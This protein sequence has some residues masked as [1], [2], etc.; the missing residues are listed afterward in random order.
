MYAVSSAVNRGDKRDAAI[1]VWDLQ[2]GCLVR[3]FRGGVVAPRSLAISRG[4]VIAAQAG[5]P[6]IHV[7][8]PHSEHLD[9]R[10]GLGETCASLAC[11]P[12]DFLCVSG[13]ASG[14]IDVWEMATGE[15]LSSTKSAHYRRITT[16]RFTNDGAHVVTASDDA[17][18]KVWRVRDLVQQTT[19]E[20]IT[21]MHTWA[22]HTLPV[23]DV[24]VGFGSL[25]ARIVSASKDC[26]CKI[27]ELMTGENIASLAFPGDVLSVTMDATEQV[28]YA[29]TG[30]GV[31]YGA[32]LHGQSADD[33]RA[34]S[35]TP[36]N[37]NT[38]V[39]HTMPV[40][41]LD[42]TLDAC[43]L[44]SGSDD[45]T[46]RVWDTQSCQCVKI[47]T[48]KERVTSLVLVP[49]PWIDGAHPTLASV[50][51]PF[52]RTLS[53]ARDAD[54]VD[55]TKGVPMRLAGRTATSAHPPL[56]DTDG[57]DG[58]G[59]CAATDAL[60]HHMMQHHRIEAPTDVPQKSHH[61][62]VDELA[63]DGDDVASLKAAIRIWKAAATSLYEHCQRTAGL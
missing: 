47:Y 52:A 44:V 35:I 11:S 9:F 34:S 7:W 18:I 61:E 15:L 13:S 58:G 32:A 20:D 12:D 22:D 59:L 54:A 50:V 30:S 2:S 17:T 4:A 57:S 8:Q 24:F 37:L 51:T 5:K 31:V 41:S 3:A 27:W 40:T 43:T 21:P 55:A 25:S 46:V 39:G 45:G 1:H 14:R 38:Y 53:L 63:D 62:T 10:I 36:K 28:V 33:L 16:I 19:H 42:V 56:D 6:A 60:M 26:S 29:G 23:T 49:R 48:H